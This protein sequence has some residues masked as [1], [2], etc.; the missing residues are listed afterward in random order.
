MFDPLAVFLRRTFEERD[1]TPILLV[2]TDHEVVISAGLAVVTTH[3]LFRNIEQGNIEAV[4]TFPLPVHATLFE[5]TAEVEGRLL[6]ANAKPRVEA[7]DEYEEAIMGGKSAV[8]HEELLRGVHMMSIANMGSGTE[9]KVSTQWT[10]P[11]SVVAGRATLRIPQTVGAIYGRS[12]LPETDDILSGGAHQPVLLSV[13][14]SSPVELAGANLAGGYARITNAEPIDLVT[15]LW[16]PSP[17]IGRRANGQ[18]VTLTLTPQAQ[19]EQALNLAVLVDH[20][21]SMADRLWGQNGRTAHEAARQGIISLANHLGPRDVVDLWEFNSSPGYVGTVSHDD[22]RTLA[23]LTGSLS[24]PSGGTEVGLAI[25]TVLTTSETRDVLVLTDGRSHALSIEMLAGS[26]RRISVILIGPDSLEARIGHLAAVT[27]GDIFIAT[28]DDLSE[29]MSA[30]VWGLRRIYRPLPR[31]AQIPDHLDCIRNN[32]ALVAQWSSSSAAPVTPELDRAAVA[33]ATSLIV[34]CATP[35]LAADMAA[36]EG[37]VSHLTSLL[38]VDEDGAAQEALPSLRKIA[39]SADR[40]VQ[41]CFEVAPGSAEENKS[42]ARTGRFSLVNFPHKPPNP[43]E[44]IMRRISNFKYKKEIEKRKYR[45]KQRARQI[46]WGNDP[47]ALVDG[48]MFDFHKEIISFIQQLARTQDVEEIARQCGLAP[49][50][51]AIGLLA[52]AIADEDRFANRVWNAIK[53]RF[54]DMSAEEIAELEELV[55][56]GL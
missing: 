11:L 23:E 12:P 2:S 10:M 51:V 33:I 15:S 41:A 44:R 13:R 6:R 19:D 36:A 24:N 32:V 28:A 43:I 26:G 47:D 38:L 18:A 50:T 49:E 20:S 31:L 25:E 30:A 21:G 4:L 46:D 56:A 29:V 8:L 48:R 42:A 35:G 16:E 17:I 37:I 3:R 9:I 7:R 40:T 22:S 1:L 55:L 14:S 45:L 5:L 54:P 53:A 39:L 34:N 52:H 27:G